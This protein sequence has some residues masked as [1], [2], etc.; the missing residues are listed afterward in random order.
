MKP[1][2]E[3]IVLVT[4][5]SFDLSLR[6]E[7]EADVGTVRYN[8]TGRPLRADEL[9]AQIADVDG[10]LA[11]L[12]KIDAGVFQA[13]PRL[14]VI[15]RYGVGVSNVDLEA[16]SRFGV[17]VTNTPG[18][19]ANAVAE[20]TIGFLFA[21]ARSIARANRSTHAGSWPSIR[22]IEISGRTVGI[23]G[24]GRIGLGVARRAK[25][26][27]CTVLGYDPYVTQEAA[28]SAVRL[29]TLDAVLDRADFVSLHLPLTAETRGLVDYT[30]L[31]RMR[32]GSFI[33]NTSRG[34]LVV[35]NDLIR[36]LG[37][38]HIGGAA[39]DTLSKEPP[40]PDH[41][42]LQ[43]D[44]VLVTPHMG[45]GTEEAALA[46]GRTALE[47]LLAVLRGE[48]PRF[49]VAIEPEGANAHS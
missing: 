32:R 47:D 46:M 16:A 10:L 13:A 26:L 22:G 36:A 45:A 28:G 19:N 35:E 48:R 3:S 7:L 4:P 41:P 5:R 27:G 38:G 37:T 6:P 25:M 34:E 20:L 1:L 30:F 42:L 29:T 44:D 8:D 12:D 31:A 49:P 40:A 9:R 2:S 17:I 23:L 15:A 11:G 43:R 24:L 18:V 33:I 21:L 39:L 14:R